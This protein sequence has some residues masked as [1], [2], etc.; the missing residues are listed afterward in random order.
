MEVTAVEKKVFEFTTPMATFMFFRHEGKI[1][2]FSELPDGF[3]SPVD[4]DTGRTSRLHFWL[5]N[6]HRSAEY[7]IK[8]I[9]RNVVDWVEDQMHNPDFIGVMGR[10][11]WFS[12]PSGG[13]APQEKLLEEFITMGPWRHSREISSTRGGTYL[14]QLQTEHD[15]KGNPLE[16]NAN[17][18]NPIRMNLR[19]GVH[20]ET[21]PKN[22]AAEMRNRLT[23]RVTLMGQTHYF[24]LKSPLFALSKV[25]EPLDA[26]T[27]LSSA[28]K[29]RFPFLAADLENAVW[30]FNNG[31]EDDK[32][33][34]I[35]ANPLQ[36]RHY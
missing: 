9:V 36:P 33:G 26:V 24:T 32:G 25:M 3:L 2:T 5:T 7:D 22:W 21:S 1:R 16:G 15:D 28:M 35:F 34:K 19:N 13:R 20:F 27:E 10:L 30:E 23:G 8:V 14:G 17:Q 11:N 4:Q 29:Q 31:G 6:L 18:C 12:E